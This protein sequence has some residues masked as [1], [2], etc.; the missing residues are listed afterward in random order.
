M[1]TSSARGEAEADPGWPQLVEFLGAAGVKDGPL[2]RT[3]T[4][5]A[6]EDVTN[7]TL[8]RSVFSILSP[9][10]KIGTRVAIGDALAATPSVGGPRAQQQAPLPPVAFNVVISFKKQEET[11]RLALPGE[12]YGGKPMKALLPQL[13]VLA[14]QHVPGAYKIV[15]L[16]VGGAR[17]AAEK[18]LCEQGVT[19]A[20]TLTAVVEE[21]GLVHAL[22]AGKAKA[23]PKAAPAQPLQPAP[24]KPI[25]ER[26]ADGKFKLGSGAT[27]T[28][29]KRGP[30]GDG[31]KV[32]KRAKPP[33][34]VVGSTLALNGTDAGARM[35][36]MAAKVEKAGGVPV[37]GDGAGRGIWCAACGKL[38]PLAKEFDLFPWNKHVGSEKHKG[39]ARLRGALQPVA[40]Q[41]LEWD[42][43]ADWLEA[44]PDWLKA[45]QVQWREMRAVRVA[46][47]RAA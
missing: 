42:G 12:D 1:A 33:L 4:L 37:A 17:L 36:A 13:D 18:A 23:V 28:G 25:P 38:Q 6:T 45:R 20:S 32:D 44:N 14:M 5:L 39:A 35:D 19:P 30:K 29:Q 24:P 34:W 15:G 46:R 10:L 11:I 3:L 41:R 7:L 2:D 26:A 16:C 8:L 21:M 47:R 43:S 31:P 27:Y 22:A 40:P 9:Q